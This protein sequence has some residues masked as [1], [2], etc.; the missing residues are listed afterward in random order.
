MKNTSTILTTAILLAAGVAQTG[1]AQ[2]DPNATLCLNI[3]LTAVSQGANTTNWGA[4]VE[5]LQYTKITSRSIIQTLGAALNDTFSRR[6]KLV[7]VAPTNFLDTWTI[8]IQDG[9]NAPV[10]VTG[11]FGHQ[12]GSPVTGSWTNRHGTQTGTVSYSI[13]T[14]SLQDQQGYPS[15]SQHFNVSGLTTLSTSS[16]ENHR[17][18]QMTLTD[19]ISAQV[20]GTGDNQGAQTVLIGSITAQGRE[21]E[22]TSSTENTNSSTATSRR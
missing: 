13:D 12:P 9:T 7:V 1:L 20:S 4:T 8:Q 21:I 22:Q 11:F 2:S 19:S 18:T 15:L 17:G 10:D 5:G 3:D 14:F 6:A 16:T